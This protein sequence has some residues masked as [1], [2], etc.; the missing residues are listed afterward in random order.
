MATGSSVNKGVFTA[1]V[2]GNRQIGTRFFKLT[3]RFAGR[4]AKAFAKTCPGQFAEIDLSNTA[5]PAEEK[6][7]EKFADS[8]KRK[9][10]LRR[11]FSFSDT[12]IKNNS[13]LVEILY[14]VAGPAS[15]RMTM[16]APSDSVSVIGPLGNGFSMPKNKK[17]ALLVI[18]GMGAGPLLHLAKFLRQKHPRIEIA[19]FVGVKTA[20]ELPFK[21]PAKSQIKPEPSLC[22]AELTKYKIKSLL[23]TDDGSLGG[24]GFV[25]HSL[26]D[27]L[28]RKKPLEKDTIIYSCGPEKMLAAVAAIAQKHNIDCQLSMERM[29]ACGI[30]LCQSCAVECK[31]DDKGETIYKLC[32]KDGPVFDSKQVI[33]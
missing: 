9:I 23:T 28:N 6:I 31:A 21:A 25:T 8:A 12:V 19:A 4:G 2:C 17:T 32:C 27:W 22:L 1:A 7:P 20:K 14:C 30:G 13:T 26:A 29:M 16:L 24:K 11:P 3:L 15:M 33:F 10:L 5:M 18:G